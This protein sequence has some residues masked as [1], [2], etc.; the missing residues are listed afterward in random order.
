MEQIEHQEQEPR[1]LLYM[2]EHQREHITQH[3]EQEPGARSSYQVEQEKAAAEQEKR[4]E[5]RKIY[6]IIQ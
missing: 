1:A 5:K 2:K 4:Q 6:N 3:Q